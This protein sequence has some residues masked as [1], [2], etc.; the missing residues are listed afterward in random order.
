MLCLPIYLHN[1][2]SCISKYRYSR[3]L[4]RP[5][6]KN[7]TTASLP[8]EETPLVHLHA[9]LSSQNPSIMVHGGD[10]SPKKKSKHAECHLVVETSIPYS[11]AQKERC[12]CVYSLRLYVVCSYQ[13]STFQCPSRYLFKSAISHFACYT[14]TTGTSATQQDKTGDT[15]K[16][17][18]TNRWFSWADMRLLLELYRDC[19]SWGR[20]HN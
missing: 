11:H 6:P 20:V 3:P 2:R 15:W 7:Y 5:V 16:M 17:N 14:R 13:P 8:L 1:S 18:D 4:L 19:L 10:L 12:C 9:A